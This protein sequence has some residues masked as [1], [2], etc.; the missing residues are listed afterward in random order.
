MAYAY[1]T[2]VAERILQELQPYVPSQLLPAFRFCL[3]HPETPLSVEQVAQA[4]GIKRRALEYRFGKA[5]LPP[6]AGC[7][8][9][10]RLLL[11]VHHLEYQTD[12]VEHVALHHAFAT[13]GALRK[14]A[15]RH[16]GMT[17]DALRSRGA[18]ENALAG[19]IDDIRQG[20]RGRR[21]H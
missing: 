14:S 12:S 17:V 18:F 9:R 1:G 16:L 8:A 13:S 5:G 2:A 4:C 15:L 11:A 10:C 3:D 20:S 19:F 6:P 21:A 7:F